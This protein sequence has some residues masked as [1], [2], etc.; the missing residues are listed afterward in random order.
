MEF[1]PSCFDRRVFNTH[2]I[3]V[4]EII[5]AHNSCK[6]VGIGQ[7]K[8]YAHLVICWLKEEQKLHHFTCLQILHS[9]GIMNGC[10]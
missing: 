3:S 1:F 6:S 8:C 2:S 9:S 10:E 4:V 7:S 5:A